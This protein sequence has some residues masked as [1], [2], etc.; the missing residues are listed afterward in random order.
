[1]KVSSNSKTNQYISVLYVE[2]QK[3]IQVE[4]IDILSL[5]V[6]EVQM[7][8]NGQ[9]GYDIFQSTRPDLIITD[10]QMPIMSGID[11]IT[12]IRKVDANIPI[13]VTS[14]FNE[15]EYLLK[16]IDLG[17]EHY[18]LKPIIVN[19]LEACLNKI[20]AHLFEKRELVAYRNN[21]EERIK[22]E[23]ALR[24]AKEALLI[25]QNKS[26][27]IGQMVSVIAHQWKQ[28][29]HHLNLLIEDLGMEYDYQ[30]LSPEYIKDF[31]KKGTNRIQFLVSTMNNFLSFY[32]TNKTKTY[33]HVSH[34]VKEVALFL[35]MSY[36]SQGINIDIIINNDFT[37]Y[38]LENEFQ[39]VILNLINNAKE[40]FDGQKRLDAKITIV[41]STNS[42]KGNFKVKDNAGGIKDEDI[43]K[44]FEL[45]FTTKNEG[46]GIGLY[47]VKKIIEERFG[48]YVHVDNQ[49]EGAQFELEF[50]LH[51]ENKNV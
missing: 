21:L 2:D 50:D 45:E 42:K 1:M 39:Q 41:I 44:V 49:N 11:M 3:D 22:K 13:I 14:A 25:E 31:I 16:A 51:E 18:L 23:I 28:P 26:Y 5:F 27:E 20:K 29:L 38:G 10:I 34:T 8:S 40:A 32:K 43:S 35:E 24:E 4:L 17:V 37:L 48:G 15:T 47:L 46:N 36:K 33:F 7:A 30:P 9:E 6:D 12:K 19:K